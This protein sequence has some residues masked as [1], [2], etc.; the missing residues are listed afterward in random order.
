M[1]PRRGSGVGLPRTFEAFELNEIMPY[2][3]VP[4]HV[5]GCFTFDAVSH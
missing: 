3:Q 1:S 5:H 4:L 2:V